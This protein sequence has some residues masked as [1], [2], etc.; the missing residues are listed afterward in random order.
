MLS[1]LKPDKFSIPSLLK[2]CA[3][4]FDLNLGKKIHGSIIQMGLQ[5]DSHIASALINMYFKTGSIGDATQVFVKMS[6]N[7]C[8]L[9]DV[10]LWNSMIDGY[11]RYDYK[12][13]G[14]LSFRRMQILGVRPDEYSLS[15]I[16][17]IC[18]DY[19]VVEHGKQVH[20]FVVRN[21][22]DHDP[23]LGTA[24]IGMYSKCRRP[25]DARKVF[26][27][28]VERNSFAW[29][30]MI[31]GYCQNE[32]WEESLEL[33]KCMKNDCCEVGS[34]TFS[35][36]LTACSYGEALIFGKVV[37]C[38]V[39]KMGFVDDP[40][41]CT[42][43]LAMYGKCMVVEDAY[44]LFD[45]VSSGGI[46]LWNAMIS[47]YVGN[48]YVEE[49]FEIY[50]RMRL[51]GLRPD[52][53]TI[54][55]ILSACSI[56]GLFDFGRSVHGELVKCPAASTNMAVQSALLTMYA[57]YGRIEEANS[58]FN[59]IKER[60]LV[61]WGSMIMGLCQKRKI[62]EAL[63]LF[64]AMELEGLKPDSEIA[65]S[66]INAFASLE[67][68]QLGCQIHGL[69]IKNGT[70][71]DVF[72][73]C[74]LIDMYA[75]CGL[76]ELA[77]GVFSGMSHKNL[78]AWNSLISSYCRSGQSDMTITL[79]AQI[80]EHG[81]IPDSVSITSVLVAIS[82]LA[83][84]LKGKMIH[85]FLMRHK[86]QSDFHVENALI[87]M[88]IKCGCLKYAR[89]IFQRMS[90]RNVVAWNSIIAGYGSHG[91]CL[92]AIKLFEEMQR[93]GLMP[94]EVTFLALIS[95]C[96]HSGFLVEGVGFFHSMSRDYGIVPQ[97]EHYANMVDL[98]GRAGCLNEAYDFI[99]SMPIEP[100]ESVWL[101]LLCACRAQNRIEL[102]EIAAGRLLKLEPERS[103]NYV[104]LLNLYGEGELWDKV[105]KLRA[106]MKERGLKKS[107]GCSWIEVKD[108]VDVFFSGDS[109][110]PRTVEI[111]ATLN[112]LKNN[113][114]KEESSLEAVP[115]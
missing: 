94:D 77:R 1:S 87:H 79:F 40:Y 93:S 73:G 65:A 69:V 114:E 108:R 78:V 85:G 7:E 60:D 49:A 112:C 81:L 51:S 90:Q 115:M 84:L 75:K 99:Q 3:S 15:I 104:H 2:N 13:E 105:A 61:A 18:R 109:S 5:S 45:S 63:D 50:N 42:S 100:D 106:L 29:N 91:D 59:T 39:I 88:Y 83:A 74:A 38:N 56:T 66:V 22:L 46:E 54:S 96:T 76:P 70:G 68:V 95:S 67:N 10:T 44:K 25:F 35:S 82:S 53:F 11:F 48:D 30:A 21:A 110:S 43:L 111:H 34:S 71:S 52:S 64:K 9:K 33:F 8:S 36:V 98:W 92:E 41:V 19:L 113:M 24:L 4:L 80:L 14:L 28:L 23:Y 27:K 32:L 62:E 26:D 6:E 16:L 57:K 107:P 47:A 58:V 97:M 12:A 101:C 55:N 17:G 72:V 103:S 31:G 20:G 37:H 89:C 102:G 86:V